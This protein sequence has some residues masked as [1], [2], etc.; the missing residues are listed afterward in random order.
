MNFKLFLPFWNRLSALDQKIIVENSREILYEKDYLI[1]SDENYGFLIVKDG[2]FRVYIMN[3]GKEITLY[4][5]INMICVFYLQIVF[6]I[7]LIL[8]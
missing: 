1:L 7:V 5:Y 6:L 8:K 3:E 2:K 4:R